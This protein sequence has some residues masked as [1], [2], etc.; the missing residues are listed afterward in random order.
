MADQFSLC[1]AE[2][3][4]QLARLNNPYFP[5]PPDA[6]Q[7]AGWQISEDDTV[8][9]AGVDYAITLK[10]GAF[11]QRSEGN[12]EFNDWGVITILWMR[13]TQYSDVWPLFRVYR[14]AVLNLRSAYPLHNHAIE[15]QVFRAREDPGYL[16]DREGNYTTVV[17]QVLECTI[18]QRR[19]QRRNF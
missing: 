14:N 5:A 9:K 17:V 18:S 7:A 4:A 3:K 10:P 8:W 19:I 16:I 2:Y 1:L 6:S 13:F 11:A 15:N 12:V